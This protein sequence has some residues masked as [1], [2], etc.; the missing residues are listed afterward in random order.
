MEEEIKKAIEVNAKNASKPDVS[1]DD[2][3]KYT[4]AVANAAN[5]LNGLNSIKSK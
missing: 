2:A 5:A 1:A 4:Q 3:M